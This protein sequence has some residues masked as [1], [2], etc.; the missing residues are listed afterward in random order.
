[1]IKVVC[2][3][4]NYRRAAWRTLSQ[5]G[6]DVAL[7]QEPC[8]VPPDVADRVEIEP[9][10]HWK[11]WDSCHS[12]AGRPHRRARIAKLSDR[13]TLD[14]FTPVPLLDP[15]S[16]DQI[17]IS[18]VHTIAAA[19]VTPLASD[20]KPFIVVSMYAHWAAPHPVVGNKNAIMPDASAHRII[21]GSVYIR[22]RL[23]PGATP[24]PG[25][26]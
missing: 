4:M 19:R 23:R 16:E 9:P 12:E 6:A 25:G 2:W 5:I 22:R 21:S 24:D 10:D 7:L 15:V 26:W 3:N 8:R 18:D 11:F 14:W 20:S 1:M 17:A 13:V